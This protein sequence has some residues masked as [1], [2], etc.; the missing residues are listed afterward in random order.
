MMVISASSSPFSKPFSS[1][2]KIFASEVLQLYPVRVRL[3]AFHLAN[4][5]FDAVVSL[6]ELRVRS[7]RLEQKERRCVEHRVAACRPPQ[8][9]SGLATAV[10]LEPPVERSVFV[11]DQLRA[12]EICECFLLLTLVV[13]VVVVIIAISRRSSSRSTRRG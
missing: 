4:G 5:L 8:S 12:R 2:G 10:D 13:V 3:R 6:L 7:I 1:V 11:A 9:T